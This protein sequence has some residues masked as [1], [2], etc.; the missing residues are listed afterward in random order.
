MGAPIIVRGNFDLWVSNGA[1]D[2]FCEIVVDVAKQEG[3][4]IS[5]VYDIAAGIAGTYGISGLGID[6][7]EFIPYFGGY[8]G[9]IQHLEICKSKLPEICTTAESQKAMFH[10]ISWAQHLL[11]GGQ[12]EKQTNFYEQLPPSQHI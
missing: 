8:E 5:E 9:F 4:D 7:S 2:F 6:T 3:N 1:K 12:I 10:I 11:A